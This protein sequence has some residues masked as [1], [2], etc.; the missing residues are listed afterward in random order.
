MAME[1]A[2]VVVGAFS[3]PAAIAIET[4]QTFIKDGIGDAL[5]TLKEET[6]VGIVENALEKSLGAIETGILSGAKSGVEYISKD[7]SNGL[8]RNQYG[9]QSLG[10]SDGIARWATGESLSSIQ[11]HFPTEMENRFMGQALPKAGYQQGVESAVKMI[12]N[13]PTDQASQLRDQLHQ[14]YGQEQT[15]IREGILSHI[16]QNINSQTKEWMPIR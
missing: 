4:V 10:Y 16:H 5:T 7:L 15:N 8:E 12:S 9:V 2:K 14:R 3:T 1:A 6:K 11:S 13:L